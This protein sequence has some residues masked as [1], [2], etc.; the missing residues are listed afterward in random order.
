MIFVTT[1]S[2]TEPFDRLVAAVCDLGATEEIV[3]Q[4]GPSK[5]RPPNAT[6][7]GYIPF[8]EFVELV[9][10]ASLVVTHAGV[11]SILVALMHS[12]RPFVVPRLARFGEAV[13]DHQLELA[14]KLVSAGLVTLVEDTSTLNGAIAAPRPE[15]S[16]RSFA[17]SPDLIEDLSA[18]CSQ[19]SDGGRRRCARGRRCVRE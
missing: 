6:C 3:V 19:R 11:G 7:V 18:I 10:R 15:G 8:V 12:K 5:M 9:E 2:S 13:D 16:Q 17:P 4:H 1:G 14:R